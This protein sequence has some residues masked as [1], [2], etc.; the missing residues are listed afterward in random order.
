MAA[1]YKL[2]SI[3][4]TPRLNF[5]WVIKD[6]L[7]LIANYKIDNLINPNLLSHISRNRQF[8]KSLQKLKMYSIILVNRN[9]HNKKTSLLMKLLLRTGNHVYKWKINFKTLIIQIFSIRRI[10]EET[11]LLTRVILINLNKILNICS[12]K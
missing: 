8:R 11:Q 3:N 10:K 4:K 5:K 12:H 7:F 1:Q 9:N 6:R 2:T